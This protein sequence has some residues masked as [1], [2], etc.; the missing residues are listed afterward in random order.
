M[1]S[2]RLVWRA[3]NARDFSRSID[4]DVYGVGGCDVSALPLKWLCC[5]ITE[6]AKQH[7]FKYWI[8]SFM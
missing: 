2:N 1:A 6:E 3:G 8:R 7:F 5:D 4:D